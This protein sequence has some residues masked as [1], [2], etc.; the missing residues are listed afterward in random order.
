MKFFKFR[1]WVL[2]LL[3]TIIQNQEKI[4]STGTTA[5]Q[6]LADLQTAVTNIQSQLAALTAEQTTLDNAIAALQVQLASASGVDP[7]AIEAVVSQ[8]QSASTTIGAA[9]TQMQ[10]EVTN[11][12]PPAPPTPPA[13]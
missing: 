1:S 13:A 12:T 6:A 8:L 5:A 3:E 10:T 11:I 9:T 2:H 7:A 4:M